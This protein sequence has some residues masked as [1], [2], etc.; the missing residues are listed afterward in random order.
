M[1]S[2]R[3]VWM[4]G[5]VA[6]A[7]GHPSEAQWAFEYVRRELSARDLAYDFALVTLEL[8][9]LHLRQGHLEEVKSLTRQMLPMKPGPEFDEEVLAA[10][11]NFRQM[12]E[13]E[14][15]TQDLAHR[16]IS[17]LSQARDNPG[18]RFEA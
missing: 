8:A 10:I 11:G 7:S 15:A 2:V 1:E 9:A 16:L 17:Y 12:A 6:A 4:E 14:T 13:Q 5:K 18:L 3:K